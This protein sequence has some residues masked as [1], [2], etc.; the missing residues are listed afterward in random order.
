[1][2]SQPFQGSMPTCCH[3]SK[4][5]CGDGLVLQFQDSL[6]T[7]IHTYIV[8]YLPHTYRC[9]NQLRPLEKRSFETPLPRPI[10]KTISRT[11]IT[12]FHSCLLPRCPADLMLFPW[13]GPLCKRPP[14]LRI[15]SRRPGNV[16]ARHWPLSDILVGGGYVM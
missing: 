1:M 10:S 3:Q 2:F 12:C 7:Y 13:I 8:T 11:Y 14:P 4:N 15:H 9:P 16:S 6:H 5:A